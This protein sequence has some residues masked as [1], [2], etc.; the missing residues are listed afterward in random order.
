MSVAL[1]AHKCVRDA[2]DFPKIFDCYWGDASSCPIITDAII[3]ARNAFVRQFDIIKAIK[4]S[5]LSRFVH[6]VVNGEYR[7]FGWRTIE[8]PEFYKCRDGKIVFICS[9]YD[10][11]KPPPV[12]MKMKEH[13][14]R[15]YTTT[16]ITYVLVFEDQAHICRELKAWRCALRE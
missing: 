7:G 10:C 8:H 9:N 6:E 5:R 11:D 3:Q 4:S 16:A 1:I 14:C 15:L 13:P 12:C 2:T